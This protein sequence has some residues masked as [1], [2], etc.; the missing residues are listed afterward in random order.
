MKSDD[1]IPDLIDEDDDN[2]DNDF[3]LP[4]LLQNDLNAHQCVTFLHPSS[5][6]L[7][8]ITIPC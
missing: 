6:L 4:A 7:V 2:D 5:R 8:R 1:E 3:H